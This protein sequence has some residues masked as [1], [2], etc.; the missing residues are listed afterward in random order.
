MRKFD[1]KYFSKFNFSDNQITQYINNALRDLEIARENKRPEVKFN[2]SYNA[3]IKSGIALI[4]KFEKAKVRSIPGHHVKIIE[5]MS[6]ILNDE[7]ILDIGNAMRMKRNEDFYA[8]GIFISEKESK[9]FFNFVEKL[10]LKV[11]DLIKKH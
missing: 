10:L 9:D 11:E 2:Y 1:V 6:E 7:L 8:G 4:A 5:R 3:L